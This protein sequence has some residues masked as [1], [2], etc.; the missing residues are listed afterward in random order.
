MRQAVGERRPVVEDE[1]VGALVPPA[2]RSTRG[3]SAALAQRSRI[4]SSMAREVRLRGHVRV[5]RRLAG[6]W[7][8]RVRHAWAPAGSS[9]LQGRPS[10]R[11]ADRGP[12]LLAPRLGGVPLDCAGADGPDPFGSTWGRGRPRSSEG[13]E[14]IASSSPLPPSVPGTHGPPGTHCVSCARRPRAAFFRGHGREAGGQPRRYR[15][16]VAGGGMEEAPRVPGAQGAALS[17]GALGA[18]GNGEHTR[19]F[20]E[21]L[22]HL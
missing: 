5:H 17:R 3:T 6:R 9:L 18:P 4:R 21:H 2:G 20:A 12:T 19:F 8:R 1:L 7:V 13:S 11:G 14:V 15:Q 22:L 16:R 10:P